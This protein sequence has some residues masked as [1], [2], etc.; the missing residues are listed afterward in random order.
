M[1]RRITDRKKASE[2]EAWER[3]YADRSVENRNALVIR[4][5]YIPEKLARRIALGLSRSISWEDLAQ[6]G[7]LGLMEAIERF[8]NSRGFLFVTFAS[9][10]IHGAIVDYQRNESFV[11]AYTRRSATR[12]QQMVEALRANLDR[13]PS[14]QETA[15]HLRVSEGRAAQMARQAHL[16]SMHSFSDSSEQDDE[17]E[18]SVN[19]LNLVADYKS[20]SPTHQLERNDLVTELLQRLP[21]RERALIE[22]YYFY[23]FTLQEVGDALGLT[24]TRVCQIHKR[25]LKRLGWVPP[26]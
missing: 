9:W 23:D 2:K 15:A 12:Y 19:Q 5:A 20:K 6:V 24:E 3:Y 25:I 11:P 18:G 4:Y 14:P 26:Q 10:R 13:A 17:G 16:V 7:M 1:T 8:D 22:L 21:E